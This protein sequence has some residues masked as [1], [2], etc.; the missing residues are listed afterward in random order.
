MKEIARRKRHE[1]IACPL[2]EH[3]AAMDGLTIAR[4]DNDAIAR[5]SGGNAA[6]ETGCEMNWSF[7]WWVSPIGRLCVAVT[8]APPTQ[9]QPFFIAEQEF[10]RSWKCGVVAADTPS[11]N[12]YHTRPFSQREFSHVYR[13][14]GNVL[15]NC[16]VS[17]WLLTFLSWI[18]LAI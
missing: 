9:P 14:M 7:E 18:L 4:S 2:N 3:S 11:Y 8:R 1:C 15:S 12:I 5:S 10:I 16:M 13:H 6:Y 17:R